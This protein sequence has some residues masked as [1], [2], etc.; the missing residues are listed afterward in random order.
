MSQLPEGWKEIKLGDISEVKSG[1][2]PVKSN[3]NYWGGTISWYT[4]GELNNCVTYSPKELITEQG[5]AESNAKLFPKGSLLIG[6]YD[7]AALKMSILDRDAAFNQAI[8]GVKPTK[9]ADLK[10]IYYA[11]SAQKP[12]ILRLRRGVRQKNL[13]L[14]KIKDITIPIATLK[15]QKR[16]VAIL[17]EAFAGI[18]NAIANTEKNLAN[19]RELF[20]SYLDS[21]FALKGKGL[22]ETNLGEIA[23]FKNG[24]NFTK[25]SN[26]QIIKIV[27]VKDFQT[28]FWIPNDDLADAQIDGTL[29]EA[30]LLKKYDILT[31]RS[32]GNQRLIGRCILSRETPGNTSHSGFTI[33]IRI[34][35]PKVS[36][37][38][39]THYLKSGYAH[40]RLINS[41]EGVNI[42]SL[43]QKAL[44]SLPI[45]Y[46]PLDLQKNIVI[47]IDLMS[48]R[49]QE[50]IAI[51]QQ[52]LTALRELKQSILQKAFSGDLT[53]QTCEP[54]TIEDC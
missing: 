19:A 14:T 27:G 38:Y 49:S 13:N 11:I 2:T 6:M 15:E 12:Q 37:V 48:E 33:R 40:H 31:V 39:L 54:Q 5:V 16:I 53:S 36:P 51:Y 7:T 1:G 35:S 43:N 30:Y 52:K 3:K 47:K 18:D 34:N 21:V 46:P 45:H 25:G 32:N 9:S 4:S 17:H 50:I 20:N 41:G 22:V 8:S 28:N 42:K 24:L 26:G 44:S 29:P 23:E 10:Y